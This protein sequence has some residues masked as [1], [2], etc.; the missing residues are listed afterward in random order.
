MGVEQVLNTNVLAF[1]LLAILV[2][3]AGCGDGVVIEDSEPESPAPTSETDGVSVVE[4]PTADS[5]EPQ[6]TVSGTNTPPTPT[7]LLTAAE[8]GLSPRQQELDAEAGLI[9]P[10]SLINNLIWSPQSDK[11][12]TAQYF[13]GIIEVWD[14]ATEQLLES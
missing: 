9:V 3:S 13:T 14:V 10:E 4:E 1:G 2:T 7:K 11:I 8:R 6:H 12:Y 5:D